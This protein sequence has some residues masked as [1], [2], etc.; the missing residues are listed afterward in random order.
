MGAIGG[1]LGVNGGAGGTGFAGP[2]SASIQQ[3]TTAAQANTA[4]S[5][6]QNALASQNALLQALQQQQGLQNQS[7]VYNQLQGVANGTGPNPAQAMLNQATGQNVANQAALMAGQ[8]GASSNVGLMARQAAQQGANTQQQAIGQGAS[9]Q[10]QQSLNALGAMGN[11]ANT[12]AQQQIGQTNANTQAQQAEQSNLLNSIQGQNN[13]LVGMQSNVNSANAGLANT[14]LQ[15]GQGLIGGVL[16]SGGS[17]LGSIGLAGGGEVK[18]YDNGGQVSS[19]G[20]QSM[21]GKFVSG[22][23]ANS[24]GPSGNFQMG[25]SQGANSLNQ[26][27]TNFGKGLASFLSSIPGSTGT[28]TETGNAMGGGQYMT[29]SFSSMATGGNVGSEVSVRLSPGERKLS[30]QDVQMVKRG[31]NPMA[32]GSV[33]PGTPKVG[34]NVDSYLNDTVEDSVP[35]GTMLLPRSVTHARD[36]VEAAKRF[37]AMHEK[38]KGKR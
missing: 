4:Y 31:A 21:F 20:P 12:Q 9:L 5:Q 15:G 30:H 10:A 14:Q 27:L 8:R 34:G 38:A 3:P 1:L 26:G 32:L 33:V 22:V 35:E 28:T 7:S 36:P 24:Q 19:S 6:N 25:G 13:N 2:T 23:G 18:R 17:L 29:P 37:I 11:L 16:N